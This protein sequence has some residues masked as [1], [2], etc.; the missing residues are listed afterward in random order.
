MHIS[1]AWAFEM[2]RFCLLQGKYLYPFY[3]GSVGNSESFIVCLSCSDSGQIIAINMNDLAVSQ[4]VNGL[5]KPSGLSLSPSGDKLYVAEFGANKI[6]AIDLKTKA[7][8]AVQLRGKAEASEDGAG[9]A[10]A[11]SHAGKNDNFPRNTKCLKGVLVSETHRASTFS[12]L[13]LFFHRRDY[14]QISS[15]CCRFYGW[16]HLHRRHWQQAGSYQTT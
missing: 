1:F 14:T 5:N 12:C 11:R 9:W 15:R 6:S 10:T 4:V 8:Q 13:P 7:V 2:E 3:P 16:N